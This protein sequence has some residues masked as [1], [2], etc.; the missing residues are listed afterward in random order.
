MILGVPRAICGAPYGCAMAPGGR[1]GLPGRPAQPYK[2][3]CL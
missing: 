2:G 3:R 1:E